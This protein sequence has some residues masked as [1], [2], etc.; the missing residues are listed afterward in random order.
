LY[1]ATH[2]EIRIHTGGLTH[3]D[4]LRQPPSGLNCLNWVAGHIMASRSNVLAMLGE[5]SV[6]GWAE[7]KRYIP[8]SEPV[9]TGADALP[10]GRILA[11][12]DRAHRQ[13]DGFLRRATPETLEA[14]C[15]GGYSGAIKTV[16][17]Q[18]AFAHAHEAAHAGQLEQLRRL[19]A[20]R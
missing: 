2:A 18:L 14:G 11:D 4:S 12:L 16:G 13:L 17:A 3:E 19:I 20:E 6:W 9:T 7:A 1:A 10:F 8:G 15:D 5:P